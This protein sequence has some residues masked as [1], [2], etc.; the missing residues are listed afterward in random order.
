MVLQAATRRLLATTTCTMTATWM[1]TTALATAR[2]PT[3]TLV[4]LASPALPR[5]RLLFRPALATTRASSTDGSAASGSTEPP[6][7]KLVLP[8]MGQTTKAGKV[9]AWRKEEGDMI[10]NGDV[11]CE[12]EMDEF[13]VGMEIDD[14]GY[15]ARICTFIY[16]SISRVPCPLHS[17]THSH[18]P[19][20]YT[21][22]TVVP[23]GTSNVPVGEALAVLVY[24]EKDLEAFNHLA[25]Y[26]AAAASGEGEVEEIPV[27]GVSLL[28]FLHKLVRNGSITDKGKQGGGNRWVGG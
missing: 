4:L 23:A 6:H 1:R 13:N 17:P 22:T 26:Q 28:K 7:F 12:V 19:P 8:D 2:P 11:V 21:R 15:L 10:K 5:R 3:R 27:D 25:P 24:E 16:G 14:K 18:H 20:P 9:T